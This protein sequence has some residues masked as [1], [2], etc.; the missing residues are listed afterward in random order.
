MKLLSRC[1][2][3]I[4]LFAGFLAS[5]RGAQAAPDPVRRPFDVT[6]Y[7]ARVEPNISDKTIK[8]L[9][10]LRLVVTA[11]NQST[12]ELDSGDLTIDAV[13]ERQSRVDFESHDRR[14]IVRWPRPAKL[15]EV[16]EIE[17]EYH[18]AAFRD[19]ILFRTF[20][21]LYGVFYEPMAGLCRCAG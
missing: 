14:L 5:E 4:G 13:K 16:R 12:I 1:L 9:V 19:S 8:G 2:L 10:I 11:E 18:G 7:S 3:A 15:N 6:H 20:S 17:V 21:G